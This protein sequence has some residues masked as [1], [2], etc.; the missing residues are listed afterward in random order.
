M[1]D[2]PERPAAESPG[3]ILREAREARGLTIAEVAGRLRLRT[4]L[5]EALERDDPAALGPG[6]YGRGQL[7]NYARL[8][9]VD[10]A[11][12]VPPSEPAP[13]SPSAPPRAPLRRPSLVRRPRPRW[14]LRIVSAAVFGVVGVLAVLWALGIDQSSP[15]ARSPELAPSAA[16]PAP[17]RAAAPAPVPGYQAAP[18]PLP[19]P[20]VAPEPAP[21]APAQ[22][23]AASSAPA[24]PAA[25]AEAAELALRFT[26]PC[27]VEVTDAAGTRLLYRMARAGDRHVLRGVPPFAVTLGNAREVEIT[28]NGQPFPKPNTARPVVRFT[29]G[30]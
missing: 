17:P 16:P 10:E 29:V 19:L 28:Y 9:G 27:W 7:R 14:P 18:L 6:P 30:G 22:R 26:G 5:V 15:P 11:R 24:A 12:V 23:S 2:A 3:A 20:P 8:L 4:H 21:G 13:L 25:S 1:S